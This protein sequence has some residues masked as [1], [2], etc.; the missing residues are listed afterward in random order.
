MTE[1]KLGVAV[2]NIRKKLNDFSKFVIK[3]KQIKN[4]KL[5]ENLFRK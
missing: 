4:I 1:I 5:F 2:L 3:N